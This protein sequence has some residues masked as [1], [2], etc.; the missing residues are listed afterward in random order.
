[1]KLIQQ[2][3]RKRKEKMEL[4]ILIPC[5]NEEKTI[6]ICIEK[7]MQFLNTNSIAEEILVADNRKY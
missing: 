6:G 3:N 5:L 2:Q 4:T 7:A 1:M